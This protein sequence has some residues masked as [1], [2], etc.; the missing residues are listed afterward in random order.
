MAV[1]KIYPDEHDAN[2]IACTAA[3]DKLRYIAY[4]KDGSKEGAKEIKET[5]T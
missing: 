4:R 1:K 3:R 5:Q 2:R